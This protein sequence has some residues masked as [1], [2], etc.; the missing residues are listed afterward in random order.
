MYPGR[1]SDCATYGTYVNGVVRCDGCARLSSSCAGSDCSDV[2]LGQFGGGRPLTF[3]AVHQTVLRRTSHVLQTCNPLQVIG[4]V[5]LAIAV[6]VV[7]F[8][9]F[10]TGS[11]EGFTYEE[12][13]VA[14]LWL[15]IPAE[16][17]REVLPIAVLSENAPGYSI[18]VASSNAANSAE[19][20]DLVPTFPP[21]DVFPVLHAGTYAHKP[22]ESQ[23]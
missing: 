15:S 19:I 7:T 11:L 13:G 18:S 3:G 22:L 23:V 10:W 1:T 17:N 21:D 14:A 4:A 16:A 8:L 6:L 5:V 2:D 20:R 9:T 12:V